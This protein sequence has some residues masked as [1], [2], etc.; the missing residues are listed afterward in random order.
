MR[1]ECLE[2]AENA[3]HHRHAITAL[4]LYA[5]YFPLGWG[6]LGWVALVPLCMLVRSQARARTL[7]LAGYCAGLFFFFPVLQW[8]RG[9]GLRP[10]SSGTPRRGV[11]TTPNVL[12]DRFS[13][14]RKPDCGDPD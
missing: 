5:C 8:M 6:I 4:L 13:E 10:V 1:L 2:Y 12:S 14:S 3:A 7:F 11:A 9:T